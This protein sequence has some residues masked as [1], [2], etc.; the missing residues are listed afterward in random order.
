MGSKKNLQIEALRGIC[1]IL[2]LIYHLFFR[3]YGI[4]YEVEPVIFPLNYLG[5]FAV[6]TFIIISC[7]F[8]YDKEREINGA[9]ALFNYFKGKLWR[10]WPLYIVSITITTFFLWIF[11]LPETKISSVSVVDFLLNVSFING[12][13]GSSYVDGAHWYLT[14]LL[15]LIFV[16]GILL[17]TKK[18]Y[19]V[20][21]HT[22]WLF[23]NIGFHLLHIKPL[24]MLTGGN[25][26]GY[27]CVVMLLCKNRKAIALK[28]VK[29][30]IS[31]IMLISMSLIYIYKTQSIH[32][33]VEIAIAIT[34]VVLALADKLG[35][36][37]NKLLMYF[38][39]ISYPLYLIHQYICYALV[40]NTSKT[41]PNVS[42]WL[43]QSGSI[44][45]VL[46]IAVFLHKS[47]SL[48]VNKTM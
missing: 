6:S 33:I 25:Y 13:I 12:F 3:Y 44:M 21:A 20:V 5:S 29:A 48:F 4:F 24:Y 36:L 41:F 10:L 35:F 47:Q 46:C 31:D 19:S 9:I 8:M 43:I 22:L 34:I 40:Y 28:N 16:Q 32:G 7:Y 1:V 39:E 17:V 11:P 38:A 15:G 45:I 37:E 42:I 18:Q 27:A 14:T 23:V 30:I 26:V 2:V